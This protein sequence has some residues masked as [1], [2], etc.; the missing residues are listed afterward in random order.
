MT[1]VVSVRRSSAQ[2]AVVPALVGG[3]TDARTAAGVLG[4]ARPT[5]KLSVYAHL[6]EGT[7]RAAID[8][9]G[10]RLERI[11]AQ[12]GISSSRPNLPADGNRMATVRPPT[13]KKARKRE[14]SL[15]EARRLEL[16]T[17]TL[18]A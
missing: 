2:G 7:K 1:R 4:H 18:P 15:V 13:K 5:V 6:F 8:S 9:L 16:L 14:P 11:S 10:D 12:A 3:G 17:L